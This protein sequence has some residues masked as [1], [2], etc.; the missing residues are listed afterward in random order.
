MNTRPWIITQNIGIYL[1]REAWHRILLSLLYRAIT[2]NQKLYIYKQALI[3]KIIKEI[4]R[5]NY[6]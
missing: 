6:E 2:T 1:G 4:P 5:I 3:F